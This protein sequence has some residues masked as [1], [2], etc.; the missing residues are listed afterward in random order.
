MRA[1]HNT[2]EHLHGLDIML[3]KGEVA[4]LEA[5][6]DTARVFVHNSQ[7]DIETLNDTIRYIAVLRKIIQA[8]K[9][10][11][12]QTIT[13]EELEQ[14]LRAVREAVQERDNEENSNS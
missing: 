5:I 14:T 8:S 4:L 7:I 3:E 6:I 11:D 2:L 10:A 13:S 1:I 12:L 9:K